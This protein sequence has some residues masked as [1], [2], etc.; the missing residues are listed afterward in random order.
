MLLNI[1]WGSLR[2][3]IIAWFFVPSALILIAIALVVF[4][5]LHQV[6]YRSVTMVLMVLGLIVPMGVL[7]V[8]VSKIAA[9]ISSLTEAAKEVA[10]GNFGLTVQASTGDE[11]EE[12]ANQFNL[13][14]R[15]LQIAYSNLEETVA[16]RTRELATLN[17]TARVLSS[18]LETEQLLHA[19][20]HEVMYRMDMHA[21]A[22]VLLDNSQ[23]NRLTLR[24]IQGF[25]EAVNAEIESFGLN[26]SI[27]SRT[28]IEG[29]AILWDLPEYAMQIPEKLSSVI[30][31]ENIKTL[32]SGPLLHQGRT[33]GAIILFSREKRTFSAQEV[34][35]LNSIGSQIGVALD[36]ANL[37]DQARQ[38]IERRRLI[39]EELIQANEEIAQRNCELTLLNQVITAI[40]TLEPRQALEAVCCSLVDAFGA[41]QAAAALLDEQ[42]SNLTVIA[43]CLPAGG[44][45]AMNVVIP[46]QENPASLYVLKHKQPLATPDVQND[47]LFTQ[48]RAIMKQRRTI[49]LLI[50][51]V[52][53]SGEVIGTIGVDWFTPHEFSAAE[54]ALAGQVSASA[55]LA[56]EHARNK[57][58]A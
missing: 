33:L 38:E 37:Y 48:V 10:R 23:E 40:A 46:V 30:K 58:S 3:K 9:P 13:M 22:I 47:I 32:V 6:T 7:A 8:G 36:N 1:R 28:I 53:Y 35:L 43:E 31:A 57:I 45:S 39:E 51:P 34:D 27:S 21:G 19:A 15:Q 2:A 25:P 18:S 12:L 50:L 52:M 55:A 24:A 29:K 16:N 14:S 44:E 56:L 20:L 41:N 26:D 42:K 4:L 49:S 17:A 5:S 11:I 54:I